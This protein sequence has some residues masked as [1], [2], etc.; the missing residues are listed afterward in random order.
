[1]PLCLEYVKVDIQRDQALLKRGRTLKSRGIRV[2]R[3][4]I[5][6]Y[7]D[8]SLDELDISKLIKKDLL[9][10]SPLDYVLIIRTR[11]KIPKAIKLTRNLCRV[12]R[13]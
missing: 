5:T 1:M 11:L 2:L 10:R 9:K 4:N 13:S 7:R 6:L 8:Y 12:V 3:P